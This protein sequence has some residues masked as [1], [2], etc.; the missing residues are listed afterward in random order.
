[1]V[2]RAKAAKLTWL[3]ECSTGGSEYNL[4][5]A[6]YV[7]CFGRHGEGIYLETFDDPMVGDAV[8]AALPRVNP[9]SKIHVGNGWLVTT[10]DATSMRELVAA[11]G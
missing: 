1:M 5:G 9:G 8:T 7:S 11:L 2:V 4:Y 6:L 10:M 3:H